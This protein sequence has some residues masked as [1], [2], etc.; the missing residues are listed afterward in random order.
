MPVTMTLQA[1]SAWNSPDRP[2][3]MKVRVTNNTGAPLDGIA[4]TL[5]IGFPATSRSVYEESLNVDPTGPLY[6]TTF[7]QEGSLAPGSTRPFALRLPLDS[8]GGL[9]DR[10]LLYP[11]RLDLRADEQTQATIRTPMVYLMQPPS[12]ALSLAWT[13]V[14]SAPMQVGPDGVFHPGPIESDIAA[15]GRIATVLESLDR[16]QPPAVDLA[17]SPVLLEE[18]QAM[19]KGYRIERDGGAVESV[20]AGFGGSKDASAALSHLNHLARSSQVEVVALPYGDAILPAVERAG[21]TDAADLIERGRNDVGAALSTTPSSSLLRPPGS[22]LDDATLSAAVDHGVRTV[23][24]NP[25][26]VPTQPNLPFSPPCV[27]ALIFGEQSATAVLPDAGVA[28]LLQG[29][30]EDPVL[31]AHQ[32][33]G[34]MAARWLEFPNL[35]GRGVAILFPERPNV[36]TAVFPSLISLVT[37]SPWLRPERVTSF[38]R[39]VAPDAGGRPVPRHA[40][41]TF[42]PAYLARLRAAHRQLD[43]FHAAATGPGADAVQQT[44]AAD[45]QTAEAGTFVS[46]PAAGARFIA[47]VDG[48]QGVIRRTYSAVAPPADGRIL[49]LSSRN[50]RLPFQ[51]TNGSRFTLRVRVAFGGGDRRLTFE[52]ARLDLTLRPGTSVAEKRVHVDAASTGRFVTFVRITTP[53]GDPIA[54]SRVVIRSTAYDRVA[55]LVTIGAGVFLAVWWGRGVL[56][57]RRA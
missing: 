46:D 32:A 49:T 15:G 7:F 25:N 38:V 37:S 20:P 47:E 23:L 5:T 12:V 40:Y 11:L 21:F 29:R 34:E 18:L 35:S 39:D 24:V 31:R 55:L 41:R 45:L 57:R 36:T 27:G 13:F 30:S 42:D 17:V 43:Q 16:P 50:G 44:L 2:L 1:Q 9:D 48:P 56:R 54:S 19:A 26:F 51:I 22:A 10:N 6:T 52:P 28:S 3:Q 14:M 33:L 53:G 4:L 8:V